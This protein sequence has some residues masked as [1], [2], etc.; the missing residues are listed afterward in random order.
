MIHIHLPT[1]NPCDEFMLSDQNKKN[2]ELEPHS[3]YLHFF[4]FERDTIDYQI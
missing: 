3:A 2:Y 1:F 4:I